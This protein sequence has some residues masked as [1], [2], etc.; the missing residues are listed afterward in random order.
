MSR[1]NK[2]RP[3]GAQPNTEAVSVQD[4]FSNPLFRLGYGSQSPLEATE[5]PLTRMTDNYALLNSLY[6]DNWVVQNVVGIIPDD[7]TKKWFAPA[8]AVGPEHLKEL[9]RVQRVT[10]LRE[11]VNEGLRWGRLYGGAAGLIM[12]RGREGMLGQPLE[13][14]SIYPGTFQGLYILDRWQGVVPGMELVFEGGEPVPAYYSITDARGNTVAKVHHSRLVRFTGR[15]L[16]FLERVAELYWGESEVEALYNDVVK[17]DNVAANMAALT[18]RANVDT[19]EVQNLDQLFSVTSG[20]QQRR[21]WNVMQAQSVMKSNFGMQLVNRGDQIKNTQYTFTGLQEVYDSMCLDL[22]GASRIPVTKLFGRSPAGMNATGE[23]DLRNYYDYVDT[24]REAKLRPILEKLLPVLAM[25]AW[26]AVPDG[27]DITFPPLWTPTAAE[28]AEIALKKAQAIRDTFQA[29]LFRA[30]TAQRELKKLA[31]E[32][33][34][35]DSISEEEIA[36]NTGK[37]YQDVTALRDPLAGLGYGGEISAPFEGAAQDAL[38]WDYSPSQPRDKKGRWTSG[39][40]NSKIG[41][42]K[43]APSKRANKR[44]KTVSAKTFGILRGEFNTKYPGAKTGQQGQVSYK[45]KRY[46]LEA[47]GSGS[48][49]VKKSW[50]E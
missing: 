10:A 27:L 30:D 38:T 41:K 43:Y 42:T 25:S 47:D 8:G 31:D 9:D 49:I 11:R 45:G 3:R 48:V 15:D 14:E 20:E 29:G 4:A 44:G 12:I 26:G 34:M 6:R 17:H 35:F 36:A 19:M 24:L 40:G 7:M 21:F 33:G 46:W 23:S 13:L 16:P 5:Y 22:S 37:T 1:R 2:S 50:K 28:V 39:G 18:F 32:T